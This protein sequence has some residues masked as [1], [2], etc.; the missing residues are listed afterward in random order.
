MKSKSTNTVS[1]KNGILGNPKFQN[2]DENNNYLRVDLASQGN[3]RTK[4]LQGTSV[5][6][7]K[8]CKTSRNF[9][10]RKVIELQSAKSERK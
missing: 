8:S 6:D 2:S 1:S 4:K 10:L 7:P 3:L 5:C 9:S